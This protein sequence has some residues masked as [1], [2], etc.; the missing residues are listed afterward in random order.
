MILHGLMTDAVP[1]G[2]RKPGCGLSPPQG[3]RQRR[4]PHERRGCVVYLLG[5]GKCVGAMLS[6]RSNQKVS[7]CW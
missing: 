3:R 5:L 6:A 2:I 7:V 1:K 4:G